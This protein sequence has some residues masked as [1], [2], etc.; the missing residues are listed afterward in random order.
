M[1]SSVL[2]GVPPLTPTFARVLLASRILMQGAASPPQR[3]LGS[4]LSTST[5]RDT[6]PSFSVFI[7]C[8]CLTRRRHLQVVEA[9]G[10]GGSTVVEP[11]VDAQGKAAGAQ[12][13]PDPHSH[14]TFAARDGPIQG[15]LGM[16]IELQGHGS[17]TMRAF[18]DEA[19]PGVPENA[20]EILR[21]EPHGLRKL[22]S[23]LGLLPHLFDL[24]G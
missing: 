20:T 14:V 9:L 6:P 22:H 11:V 17:P 4:Q 15:D 10:T 2:P 21:V 23:V 16:R 1:A 12:Q 18:Q 19:A 8:C 7:F 13:N 3:V 5:V 24:L